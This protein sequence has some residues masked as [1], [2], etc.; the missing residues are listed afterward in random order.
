MLQWA[1]QSGCRWSEGTCSRA[2]LGGHLAILQWARHIGCH[3]DKDT[4]TLAAAGGHLTVLQWARHNGCSW[5]EE[6]C[7]YAA[8]RGHLAMLQWAHKNN[9]PWSDSGIFEAAFNNHLYVLEWARQQ[10]PPVPWWSH[11]VPYIDDLTFA[12][13]RTLLWLAQ[14]GAPLPDEA[15]DIACNSANWLTHAYIAFRALLP[16]E[17]VLYILTISME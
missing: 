14:Q 11:D 4:C 10:Q 1:R 16:A 9:C 13:D 12:D 2:A 8:V 17:V 3:W 6:T 15:Y 5:D 7:A